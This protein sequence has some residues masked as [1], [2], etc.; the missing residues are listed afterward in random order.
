[1][2]LSKLF[3]VVNIEEITHP[4]AYSTCT[5]SELKTPMQIKYYFN[6]IIKIYI[7]NNSKKD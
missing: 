7:L 5:A 2:L 3:Y 4:S 6:N 1:M